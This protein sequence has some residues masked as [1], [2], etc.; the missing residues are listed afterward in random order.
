MRDIDWEFM[1]STY[2]AC[3]EPVATQK[4]SEWCVENLE[5]N[6]AGN[7]GPF[8]LDGCEYIAELLD[9][10]AD[11]TINDEVLVFGS[12]SRK[13][14]SLMGGVCWAVKH[15]PSGFLWVM[16]SIQ[17]ARKF[18]RQRFKRMIEKSPSLAH[19]IPTGARRHEFS[20]LEMLLGPST[21][22]FVGSNSAAN[23]SS[24]PC[25]R[26]VLDEV[27]KFD[28][29]GR[30]EADAVN[31]AEQRTKDQVNPQRWKTS[32]P[33]LTTGL[34]W[35]EF[36]KGDQR[37][38]FVP[39]PHCSQDVVFAWS[40]T[41]TA[42]SKT[43]KEAYMVWDQSARVDKA[44]DFEKVRQTAHL[45]CPHCKGAIED[46]HKRGLV[47]R[48]HWAATNP[49]APAHF[50]SRHLPSLYVT[51]PETS[52]GAL[53]V[54]F[55]QA[56]ASAAGLRGFINGDLA[57]PYQFQDRLKTVQVVV[58]SGVTKTREGI[59]DRTVRFGAGD[60][61]RGKAE[62]G[63][64]PHWWHVIADVK[65]CDDGRVKVQIVSE[66]KLLTESNLVAAF[67]EHEV[68]SNCVILDSGWDTANVYAL[69]MDRGYYAL[70]SEGDQL[71]AGHPDGGKKV[72]SPPKPLHTMLANMG[73]KHEYVPYQGSLEP[74]PQ[75]PMFL[76]VAK[77]PLMDFFNWMRQAPHVEF[78]VPEDVSADFHAHLSAWIAEDGKN[79]RGELV[80][81]WRQ[82][83][84]RD[85]L[86]QCCCY[87]ALLML[88]G[89]LVDWS[90]D[91]RKT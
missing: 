33:T 56:K 89:G 4:P 65:R 44:W 27:D 67:Q 76:H 10:W 49:A 78:V 90:I 54:K 45:A 87:I 71:F 88:D 80:R 34:I 16:P 79:K 39:C 63:E 81:Q 83:K 19:L 43:G 35:Q 42:L 46:H 13:T 52:F 8:R 57:E 48:G 22:N 21:I 6:E 64:L 17:L 47:K 15:D 91:T 2:L 30:E 72:Y 7:H 14:G 51:S 20:T 69:C 37:R 85:D 25:R 73:P 5:F 60:R 59:P 74:H 36:L 23:L 84:D 53:A 3:L 41:Y 58:R 70:K 62:A 82:L 66:G 32:T 11:P 1:R 31:L 38:Y 68:Q 24:N 12:Q 75:E 61:Q 18:S 29:G 9:D 55:L 28:A 77:Y 40:E 50:R 26:V 86:Y